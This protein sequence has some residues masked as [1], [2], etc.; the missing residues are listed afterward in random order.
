MSR[1]S[2]EAEYRALADTTAEII[3]LRWLLNDFS[4]QTP[5]ATPLYS[6]SASAIK[7][8]YNDVFHERTKHIEVDCHFI[9]HHVRDGTIT[10]SFIPSN[11]QVADFFT[12]SHPS[13]R[14]LHFVS[15]LSMLSNS[16]PELEG[17]CQ[18]TGQDI[19]NGSGQ[20]NGSN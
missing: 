14:F 16:Y 12:K 13:Q 15:K 2:T 9:R 18:D 20:S 1:S 19:A 5:V 3:W 4:V 6:D 10:I 11:D 7:I 17:G 8:A